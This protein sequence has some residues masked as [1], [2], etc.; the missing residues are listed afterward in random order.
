MRGLRGLLGGR[1]HSW[2]YGVAGVVFL[3]VI[4]EFVALGMAGR[5]SVVPSPIA[6]FRRLWDDR[7]LYPSQITVTLKEAGLGWLWG[8]LVALALA[9]AFVL[10]PTVESLLL[11]IAVASYC[12]PIIAI[13]PILDIVFTGEEPKIV[14]AAL[15]VIFTTLIGALQ[16]L[17]SADPVA[18][19]LIRASGGGTTA[20]LR[21]VR[22]RAALPSTFA[23]LQIAAPAALLGAIIGQFLGGE[24]GL[25]V[26]MVTSES[27]FDVSRTWGI[28]IVCTVI[29]WVGYEITGIIGKWLTP[30]AARAG[31][32]RNPG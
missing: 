19:D 14:L 31:E 15:S 17:R 22:L 26:F 12:M 32:Q 3:L 24:R 28:A 5:H 27:A 20:Q 11:K 23:G 7:G 1:S 29:A 25:G 4:W 18:L 30:W 9:L 8:N 6:V 2:L 16:G 21:K 10:V 13:G